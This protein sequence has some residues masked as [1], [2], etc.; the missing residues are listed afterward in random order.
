MMREILACQLQPNHIILGE[1]SRHSVAEV[2]HHQP[3]SDSQSF[4]RAALGEV[5][6]VLKSGRER[7]TSV[8]VFDVESRVVIV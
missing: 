3:A 8:W 1:R 5:W 6:V 4:G 2:F 7:G